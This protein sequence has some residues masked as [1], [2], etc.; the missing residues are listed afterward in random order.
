MTKVTPSRPEDVVLK[1]NQMIN[2]QDLEGLS[3]LMTADHTFIDSSDEVHAGKALM[4]A[5]WK[6]FFES[7]PDYRNHFVYL[8]TRDKTVYILGHSTCS[9]EP[10]DGPAIWIARVVQE[11][12]AEWR[13]YLDNEDNRRMLKLPSGQ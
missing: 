10:L 6:E 7:Y 2:T 8:E 12:I 3:E 13:V 11:Q 9:Y 1:F 5:G 4:V